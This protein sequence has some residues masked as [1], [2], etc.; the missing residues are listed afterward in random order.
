MKYQDIYQELLNLNSNLVYPFSYQHKDYLDF[1][2]ELV[3]KYKERINLLDEES[4]TTLNGAF[5]KALQGYNNYTPKKEHNFKDNFEEI[6]KTLSSVLNKCYANYYE[7]AFAELSEFFKKDD[8]FYLKILPKMLIKENNL[9]FRIRPNFT[10]RDASDGGLF[11]V[12]FNARH[13]IGSTRYGFPGYPVLYLA[14]SFSTAWYE[15][16]CPDIKTF[17]Y[18]KF[19]NCQALSLL[20]LGYPINENP[21]DWEYYS[22]LAFYPLI[23]GCLISVRNPEDPFKPEYVLPQLMTKIIREYP[24]EENLIIGQPL[25]YKGFNGILYMSTKSPNKN[26][27]QNLSSRNIALLPQN[28]ICRSGYDNKYLAPKL[29]ITDIKN[30]SDKPDNL[31]KEQ[32]LGYISE[33]DSFSP[34]DNFHHIDVPMEK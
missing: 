23:M 27:L 25:T 30:F 2:T 6:Y 17:S 29:E 31:T 18:A 5:K 33:E 26:K 4:I 8:L 13:K 12:P 1:W 15:M 20:D 21:E 32:Q 24:Q 11:H 19:K 22:F 16:G 10:E 9:F 14:Y 3:E 7:D 34:T 28:T